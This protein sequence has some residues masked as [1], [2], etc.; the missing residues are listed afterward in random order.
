MREMQIKSKPKPSSLLR[1]ARMKRM[2]TYSIGQAKGK[3]VLSYIAGGWD[4][5]LCNAYEKS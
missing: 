3:Q 4:N 2:R 5:K 1:L